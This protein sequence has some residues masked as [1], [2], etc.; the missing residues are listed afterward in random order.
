MH[1]NSH[2]LQA[3]IKPLPCTTHSK[4]LN[5]D[6]TCMTRLQETYMA[7]QLLGEGVRPVLLLMPL[8]G[9]CKG[10]PHTI[11]DHHKVPVPF[12]QSRACIMTANTPKTAEGQQKCSAV[13]HNFEAVVW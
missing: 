10:P 2:K 7:V 5:Q 4:P 8:P 12:Q 9:M 6:H 11:V 13:S 3:H 1:H